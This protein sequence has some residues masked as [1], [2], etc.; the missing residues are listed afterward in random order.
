MSLLTYLYISACVIVGRWR[1][2]RPEDIVTCLP[3]PYISI[4]RLNYVRVLSCLSCVPLSLHLT[5]LLGFRQ[6]VQPEE[7][8]V[9]H[10]TVKSTSSTMNV[11]RRGSLRRNHHRGTKCPRNTIGPLELL[12]YTTIRH[13]Y[14]SG[15]QSLSI[16]HGLPNSQ[17]HVHPMLPLST[18]N[19]TRASGYKAS[20]DNYT[21]IY[22]TA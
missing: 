5:L 16:K 6:E 12:N 15:I 7:T 18:H 2:C 22:H 19:L 1:S 10:N 17:S 4:P 8:Q 14:L 13:I 21:F 3:I 11:C 20:R 9:S